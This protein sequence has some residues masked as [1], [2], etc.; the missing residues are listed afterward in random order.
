[1]QRPTFAILALGWY[2]VIT[3]IFQFKAHIQERTLD[4]PRRILTNCSY[5]DNT[6]DWSRIGMEWKGCG[7]LK[8]SGGY[9]FKSLVR[10]PREYINQLGVDKQS[11]V[12]G[13]LKKPKIWT[14]LLDCFFRPLDASNGGNIGQDYAR[15]CIRWARYTRVSI[16]SMNHNIAFVGAGYMSRF[17]IARINP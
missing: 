7:Q 6:S 4:S 17:L 12:Q 2:T 13:F 1:M 10:V 14:W 8:I 5:T 16:H 3:T 11:E 9:I 15:I